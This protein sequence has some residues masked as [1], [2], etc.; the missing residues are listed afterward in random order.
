[1]AKVEGF[2]DG[3]C[4]GNPGPAEF[5]ALLRCTNRTTTGG[6]ARRSRSDLWA[7]LEQLDVLRATERFERACARLED[8][9][10]QQAHPDLLVLLAADAL[11]A[12][13]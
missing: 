10:A 7:L 2:T 13:P 9:H 4:T 3:A 6:Q 12:A 1:M 11:E 8:A 5:A